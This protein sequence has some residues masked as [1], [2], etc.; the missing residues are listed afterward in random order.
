MMRLIL[1]ITI[2]LTTST[3]PAEVS[4]YH[5]KYTQLTKCKLVE[6]GAPNE[7]DY[8]LEECEGTSGYKVF[9]ESGD[10]R[11]WIVLKNANQEIDLRGTGED[12]LYFPVIGSDKLEWRYRTLNGGEEL[13]A[14]IVRMAGNDREA[15]EHGNYDKTASYLYIFRINGDKYCL[16]S[17][18]RRNDVARRIA[19]DSTLKC[20]QKF[21]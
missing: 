19:D 4:K 9:L 8:M 5:S 7:G 21:N 11:S 3:V 20:P 2:L 15:H 18:A 16:L 6:K 1:I 13:V 14:I 17:H 12:K 10:L